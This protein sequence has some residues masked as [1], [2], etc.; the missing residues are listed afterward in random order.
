MASQ[1]HWVCVA[2]SSSSRHRSQV[3]SSDNPSLKKGSLRLQCPVNSHTTH[4]SWSLFNFKKSFIHLAEGP[5]INPFACLSPIVDSQC[6]FCD[7]TLSSP[8]PLSWQLQ[9]RCRKLVQVPWTVFRA[10]SWQLICR[11]HIH[12][13]LMTWHP[14]QLNSVMFGQLYEG[15]AAVPVQFWGDLVFVKCFNW[16]WLSDRL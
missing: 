1:S 2:D 10:F 16:D 6:F 8:W 4:L 15:L 12:D 3:G 5:D 7:V 11:F 14:Y 9:L 13:T